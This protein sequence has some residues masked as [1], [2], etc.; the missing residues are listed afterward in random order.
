MLDN[1]SCLSIAI[2]H[3]VSCLV[4]IIFIVGQGSMPV[5]PTPSNPTR[6][7]H[8]AVTKVYQGFE[9][10]ACGT[11]AHDIN[12]LKAVPCSPT[13]PE[14]ESSTCGFK[15]VPAEAV[16]TV[17]AIEEEHAR[18]AKLKELQEL[19]QQLHSLVLE[20]MNRERQEAL[21][22]LQQKK[23]QSLT[24]PASLVS[25][26]LILPHMACGKDRKG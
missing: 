19:R 20:K 23:S 18:L 2:I 21:A 3:S 25:P 1:S 24:A 9:C 10:H 26:N 4:C 5:S 12:V 13:S 16:T 22:T 15:Y 6:S 14:S 8:R 7:Y 11:F 17:K